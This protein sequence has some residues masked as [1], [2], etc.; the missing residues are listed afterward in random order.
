MKIVFF[1]T[2][3]FAVPFLKQ[4]HD[5]P[6]IEVVAVVCQPD[7]PAGRSQEPSIPAVKTFALEKSIPVLQFETLRDASAV[8]T[9]KSLQADAFV[10]VVYGKILPQDVLDIAPLGV[11]NVHPS[12]LPKYRGPSPMKTAILNGERETGISIMLLDSGMDSGPVLAQKPVTID[13]RETNESLEQKM[14]DVGPFFLVETLKAYVREDLKPVPQDD[15]RATISKLL[16]R[17]DGHID[18]SKTAV[19]IDRQLRA[20]D[21]WP[22]CWTLWN[23]RRLK[24][25][26]ASVVTGPSSHDDPGTVFKNENDILVTTSTEFIRLTQVQL[27]GKQPQSIEEFVNGHPDFITS[28]LT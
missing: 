22:G 14:C 20:F 21:P 2:P 26:S 16:S 1:G 25:L 10:L 23:E 7:K 9:L 3:A 17:D 27:E 18:W 15:S 13:A 24:I 12:M 8:E 19:E 5:D 6:S 11:V 4:L 28:R